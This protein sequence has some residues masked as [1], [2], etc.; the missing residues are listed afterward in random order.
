MH[1]GDQ[2]HGGNMGTD[3]K[4]VLETKKP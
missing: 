4:D 3:K 1:H 2:K